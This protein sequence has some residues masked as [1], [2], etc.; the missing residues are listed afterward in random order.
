MAAFYLL[1]LSSLYSYLLF[2]LLAEF[3]SITIA[4]SIFM[5]SWHARRFLETSAV[6]F[7]GIGYFFVGAVDLAHTVAA[8]GMN[9]LIGFETG[10]LSA[11]LWTLAR[12]LQAATLL[13]ASL[14]VNRKIS[15][16]WVLTMYFMVTLALLVLVLYTN[17]P[18]IPRSAGFQPTPFRISNEYII[19][20]ILVAAMYLFLRSEK[21]FSPDVMRWLVLSIAWTAGSE[22]L[23]TWYLTG[24]PLANLFGHFLKIVAFYMVYRAVTETGLARP[25]ELVFHNLQESRDELRQ[26][27]DFVSAILD[28]AFAYLMV[29]DPSGHIIRLNRALEMMTGFR[30]EELQGLYLWDAGIF[31]ETQEK[32]EEIRSRMRAG[33]NPFRY[34]GD[35]ISRDQHTHRIA[36][37]ITLQNSPEDNLTHCIWT[38]IDITERVQAEDELRYLS[39]HDSLTG[40]FNRAYF[41]AEMVRL[42][43]TDH[44]PASIVIA[45]LDGLKIINDS[46]GHLAGDKLLQRAA[47]IL[48]SAFRSQDVVA[49]MGGDEFAVLLAD[50]DE[51]VA[52]HGQRRVRAIISAHNQVNPDFPISLSLGAASAGAGYMLMETFKQADQLMYQEKSRTKSR[53]T[54]P[55]G[56]PPGTADKLA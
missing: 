8:P 12:Y 7:I 35:I 36:W 2:H 39:T 40:L 13:I 37:S 9:I 54:D 49:R 15:A 52:E 48:R 41:E 21:A 25:Y 33:E 27:R 11:D 28:T 46:F 30:A 50:A 31:P 1:Y 55:E 38:G 3:F 20:I 23:F 53:A 29:V 43:E 47:H 42:A 5:V 6:L 19:F 24:Y 22:L 18:S 16:R 26:E 32:I 44:F 51:S 4:L 34:D 10:H 45:D 56:K 14:V 17:L